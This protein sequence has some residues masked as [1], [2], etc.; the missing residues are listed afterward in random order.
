MILQNKLLSIIKKPAKY[1]ENTCVVV[2]ESIHPIAPEKLFKNYKS[3]HILELGSGWGEFAVEW[4]LRNPG[5]EYI[6]FE[7]KPA[8]IKSMIKKI[9]KNKIQ[10]IK[11][12]PVNYS[13]F[14]VE[15]LPLECFDLILLNFPDPWPKK[16]HWKHRIVNP[17][18]PEKINSLLKPNGLFYFASD[19]GPYFR[20]VLKI[21]RNS[22]YFRPLIP[23]PNYL[24]K[25]LYFFPSSQ[26]EL[27][28]SQKHKPWY[29]LWR[30]I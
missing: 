5:H 14:L 19:Y 2:P 24:R 11:I 29:T 23:W 1:K 6:A 15:I 9:E 8:R 26:F 30:K 16:R 20:K 18:F 3:F 4:I 27:L 21:F 12:L 7:Q 17:E 25:R 10:N 22:S 13:W 28:T